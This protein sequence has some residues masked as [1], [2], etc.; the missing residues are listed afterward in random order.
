VN[1]KIKRVIIRFLAGEGNI[2]RTFKAFKKM[3]NTNLKNPLKEKSNRNS[4]GLRLEVLGFTI[5]FI[6]GL[7]V[8]PFFYDAVLFN[9]IWT[10]V[11]SV[12]LGV[13]E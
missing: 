5:I 9:G 12:I 8:L 7:L 2:F 4:S 6:I 3:I 13:E 10:T 1:I 11:C